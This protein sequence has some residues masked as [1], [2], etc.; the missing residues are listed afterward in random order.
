MT[1]SESRR[2]P[3]EPVS[4]RTF[5]LA[6]MVLFTTLVAFLLGM[7]KWNLGMGIAIVILS[8]PA[9]IR[10]ALIVNRMKA[11]GKVVPFGE[12]ILAFM[13]SLSVVGLIA[14][15]TGGAFLAITY[16]CVTGGNI[17]IGS[18][19]LVAG[20]AIGVSGVIGVVLIRLF[21]LPKE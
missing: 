20:F 19:L 18:M 14:G 1:E 9:L 10:T 6:S 3:C 8:V 2:E 21:W 7:T 4:R 13:R 5:S 15:A 17:G 16:P 12:K 11:K